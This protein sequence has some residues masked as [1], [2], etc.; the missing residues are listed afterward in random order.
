MANKLVIL[1]INYG[2][3]DTSAALM[4]NGKLIAACEEE[5]FNNKKHTRDF[6]KNSILECLKIAGIKKNKINIVSVGFDQKRFVY[7]KYINNALIKDNNFNLIN[8]DK[9]KILRSLNIDNEIKNFFDHKFDFHIHPHHLC[10]LASSFYPSGFKKSFTISYDGKGESESS[11]IGIGNKNSIKIINNENHYP[12][13]LGMIYE[14]VT[15][16]LGWKPK[17]D[18]GIVMGLAPYGNPKELIPG[19]NYRYIDIFR[20]II[21][22]NS[23]LG[24]KINKEWIAYHL[25]RD[26]WVSDK[27]YNLFGKKR[28]WD[29]KILK[30][31]KDIAAALQLRIEEVVLSQLKFLQKK[32][33][34]NYLCLS[35]GVGLNCSLNGKIEKSKTF[36]KIFVTPASGDAG[37][38]IGACYLSHKQ[39]NKN[40]VF[41]K[42][43]N[44]YLGSKFK[45]TE[46]LKILKKEKKITYQNC[47]KKINYK[48]AELLNKQKIIAWFQDR[49][50]MGPRALG[51][52][53]ILCQPFP[54]S[55]KDYLNER[56]K[57]REY[58]R[59]FAPAVLKEKQKK[60]FKINQ[61]SYHMLIACNVNIK[62]KNKIEAVVHVDNTC[63][64]QT[65]T[66][67]SNKKFYKLIYEFYKL[68]KVPVLLN[69]SFNVK[70]QP[71]VNNPKQAV[72]TL[73]NTNI[74]HLVINNFLVTKINK[75][76]R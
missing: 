5:R 36:K 14:A 48:T 47:G 55:M 68:T 21:K 6:P 18:E 9:E 24:F 19:K 45:D 8:N 1:G 25:K 22:I 71:M 31:H 10:H 65:V 29:D 53:S 28:N 67:K 17:C 50:E 43:E 63:R 51:N 4:I 33:K 23:R 74:D 58:F 32:Y 3:H 40:F 20:K 39:Q 37:I 76:N 16:Y 30:K 64:V 61:D 35:G 42:H 26:K 12:N 15:Y 72:E 41:R 54:K 13:S 44:F 38:S 62:N 49:S 75:K 60:Y 7:E 34:I 59:P 2:G 56:V 69:T 46:I 27:F 70:G 57:F 66:K 52:R 73:L 11:M